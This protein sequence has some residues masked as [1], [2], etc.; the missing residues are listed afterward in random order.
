[1]PYPAEHAPGT[2]GVTTLR[3]RA[4]HGGALLFLTKSLLQVVTW[5]VTILVARY[6]RPFDYGILAAGAV[7]LELSDRV[8]ELGITRALVRKQDL[9]DDDL[10]EA[11]TLSLVFSAA[12][13]VFVYASAGPAEAYFGSADVAHYLRVAGLLLLL[14]PFRAVPLAR[15]EHQLMFGRVSALQGTT[16]VLQSATV[17]G[18]AA[19]GFGYWA[20]VIGVFVARV[21][22]VGLL[23][24]LTGWRPRLTHAR[25]NRRYF[26]RFGL[27]LTGT[28]LLY[29]AY[30]SCDVIVLGRLVGPVVLGYYS[31]AFTLL[32]LPVTKITVTANQVVYPILCRLQDDRA[33]LRDWYLRFVGIVGLVGLPTMT[34]LALVAGDAI[35]LVLGEQWR[36]AVRPLQLMSVAGSVM[37]I[38]NSLT[39][40][41]NVI[42]RPDI[43]LRYT[44]ACCVA[45]P[46]AFYLLGREAG[47]VGV[48]IAWTAV[49]PVIACAL[50]HATRRLTGIGVGDLV[51][52]LAPTLWGLAAMIV[53]VLIVDSQLRGHT[54]VG[55]LA[56]TIGT[57]ALVFT[58]TAYYLGRHTVIADLR[59]LARE[60]RDPIL[61][62]PA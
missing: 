28:N 5:V 7:L 43:N 13:Y 24:V 39:P 14:V 40:V 35:P 1:M 16:T 59:A 57:G 32:T 54:A 51:R 33:R 58:C 22:E 48:A 44:L 2:L 6:L 11:F 4:V 34:G 60:V 47:A 17:L 61:R 45:L 12:A 42:D 56:M 53:V 23:L 36:P 18:F 29:V 9:T 30:S 21:T 25:A 37:V 55:R 8:A 15:L 49:F 62:E 50:V 27:H 31:L 38:V 19:A 46:P 41:F 26:V 10:A 20:P 3:R 52:T